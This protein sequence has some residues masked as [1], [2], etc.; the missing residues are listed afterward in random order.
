MDKLGIEGLPL[1]L[2]ISLLLISLSLPVVMDQIDRQEGEM[3]E[4]A[5]REKAEKV[6]KVAVS[7]YMAGPG[8]VRT[9]EVDLSPGSSMIIGG[10]ISDPDSRSIRF[11][12]D[13]ESAGV[14]YLDTVP[15]RISNDGE[16]PLSLGSPGGQL[17]I[18]CVTDE[19]GY[20]VKVE[21]G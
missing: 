14:E 15:V 13:G 3:A 5:V 6:K 1:R 21:K 7:V 16:S 4:L 2:L 18:S 9:V 8:N 10:S 11:L 19:S 20:W 12:L 17:V